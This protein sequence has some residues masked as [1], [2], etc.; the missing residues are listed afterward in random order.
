[1]KL[2]DYGRSVPFLTLTD[3][4]EWLHVPEFYHSLVTNNRPFENPQFVWTPFLLSVYELESKLAN[5]SHILT[6]RDD[7]HRFAE[8][9]IV[10]MLDGYE[11]RLVS[12][13][14]DIATLVELKRSQF[15]FLNPVFR[16]F[17]DKSANM[18]FDEEPL[19]DYWI[20]RFQKLIGPIA[21]TPFLQ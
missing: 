15:S 19:Y 5:K 6:R 21:D 18:R 14:T 3:S 9:F 12:V 13:G 7:M 10:L 2:I 1:M 16:D 8:L 20:G 11:E 17:F 4:E